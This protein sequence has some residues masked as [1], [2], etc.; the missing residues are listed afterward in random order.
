MESEQGGKAEVSRHQETA[1][2][3]SL[4]EV[5]GCRDLHHASVDDS[6]VVAQGCAPVVVQRRNP[7]QSLG[8]RLG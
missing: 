3:P 1:T 4:E 5:D 2:H 6:E 7:S 8:G